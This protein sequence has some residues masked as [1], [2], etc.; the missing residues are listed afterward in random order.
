[1]YY[2]AAIDALQCCVCGCVLVVGGA[3][4]DVLKRLL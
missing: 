4:N 1:M 2:T 3:K